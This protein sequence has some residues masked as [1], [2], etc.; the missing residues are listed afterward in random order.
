MRLL[1]LVLVRLSLVMC[2]SENKTATT[3]RYKKGE[4]SECNTL[5]MLMQREDELKEKSSSPDC[6]KTR[7]ITKNCQEKEDGAGACVFEKPKNVAWTSCK[8]GGG[9]Q[10]ESAQ[11]G[12]VRGPRGLP[13]GE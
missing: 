11:A 5:L 1:C 8:V 4:W 12:Q 3:C 7:T 6:D 13:Q 2:A 9:S 10:A